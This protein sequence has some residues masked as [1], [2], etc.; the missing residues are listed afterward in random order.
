MLFPLK[1]IL[2]REHML[3]LSVVGL[4][5]GAGAARF[6]PHFDGVAAAFAGLRRDGPRAVLLPQDHE[7]GCHLQHALLSASIPL[8]SWR[9]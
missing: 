4:L 6:V 8:L 5:V 3:A 1:E 2:N 7:L 9:G